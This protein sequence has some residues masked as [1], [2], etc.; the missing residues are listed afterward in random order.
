MSNINAEVMKVQR[1][2]RAADLEKSKKATAEA[3]TNA[4]REEEGRIYVA[5]AVDLGHP[6]LLKEELELAL[7]NL[8]NELKADI[9]ATEKILA[10]EGVAY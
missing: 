1:L 8:V 10:D 9:E 4:L 2:K 6:I 7:E 5:V 3:R